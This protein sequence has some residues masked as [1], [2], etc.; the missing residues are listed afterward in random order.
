MA[1]FV[2]WHYNRFLKGGFMGK[3]YSVKCHRMDI[4]GNG[5]VEFNGSAFM[6]HTYWMAKV[7]K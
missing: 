7:R 1:D 2:S 5:I 6:Y 3:Q 4:D